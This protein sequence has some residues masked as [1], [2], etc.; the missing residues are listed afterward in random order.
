MYDIICKVFGKL[1]E[2]LAEMIGK[3]EK[4][5]QLEIFKVPLR[6]FINESHELVLLARKIDWE[7]LQSELS[8]YYCGDNGRPG[9]PI[10]TI[11]GIVLLKQIFDESDENVLDRWVENPYWQYF[12]GEVYFR[13]GPPLTGRN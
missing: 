11:A 9:I 5:P 3:T 2:N 10:R 1:A 4:N 8:V 13:Y 12:C 6:Q 7:Q